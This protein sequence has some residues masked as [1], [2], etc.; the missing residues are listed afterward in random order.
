[1]CV[2]RMRELVEGAYRKEGCRERSIGEG[3]EIVKGRA[4]EKSSKIKFALCSLE[5]IV[6]SVVNVKPFL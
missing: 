2:N 6:R 5:V 1:M 3:E 4:E